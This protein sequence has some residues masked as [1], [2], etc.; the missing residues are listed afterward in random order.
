MPASTYLC[1][2][3]E[4]PDGG[5]RG[6]DPEGSG[7]DSLFVVRQ[8]GRLFGYRDQCPHY[9]D[10]P[11]AWRRHAYLNA[12]GSRIVCAAHG[13]LFQVE[14]GVCVQGPCLGQALTPV[15]LTINSDG[16][17]HLMRTSGRPRADEVEQRT[18]DL[19]QVAA[20]LFMAQGYAH[21]SLRTIAAEARVAARTIYAKFG[22]KLGLFEAV[23]AHERDRM[24]DQLDEQSPDKRPLADLLHDFCTRYLALVNTPRAI[25]TQRM[26]IAEAAQNPQLGRVF[27]DAGPG[28]LRA[29]LTGLFAHPKVQGELRPG[30]SPEQLTNFLLSCLLGDATQRLLRQPEQPPNNHTDTVQAALAAFF[31]VAGKPA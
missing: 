10:T 2:M 24:M 9:G 3:V 26:V 28:A 17:V 29:R 4:L 23:V 8:G 6:F 30:L 22:G 20:E 21:V 14:D 5:S 19:L 15:P 11:M 1:R 18:R 25:A 16:E 7:Q 31:A 13:A 27:Y 12:A